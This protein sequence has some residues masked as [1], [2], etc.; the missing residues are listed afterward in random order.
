MFRRFVPI[1]RGVGSPQ[2][3][4]RL[5]AHGEVG[6]AGGEGDQ[7]SV[8]ALESQP[9]AHLVEAMKDVLRL[10]AGRDDDKLVTRVANDGIVRTE[11]RLQ[12]ACESLQ[13]LVAGLMAV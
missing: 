2:R 6:V 7:R 1:H 4:I 3:L 10:D 5:A 8:T 13:R 9:F 12:R 11:A